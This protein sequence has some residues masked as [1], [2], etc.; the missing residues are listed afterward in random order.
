M[1]HKYSK[2]AGPSK[3]VVIG[4]LLL[5][6]ILVVTGLELTGVTHIFH[7]KTPV[8]V[9]TASSFN[10]KGEPKSPNTK[11]SDQTSN[12]G[13]IS[14]NSSTKPGGSSS[15]LITPSGDFVSNHHPNLS[16]T[17]APNL[18]S[19]VCNSTPG[20]SC[21]ITFTKDGVVKSLSAQ[22]T[23]SNGSVYWDWKL[24]DVGL[25]EGTWKIQ[26]IASLNGQSKTAADT[27][28]LVVSP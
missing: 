15:A 28:D 26:A 13:S 18:I 4:V 7:K 12:S 19:S 14:N 6:I 2:H 9:V 25:T 11:P 10:T 27:L 21:Q 17:P 23:D 5:L 1:R 24:Q 8:V 3:R 20:A 22:N 16:G